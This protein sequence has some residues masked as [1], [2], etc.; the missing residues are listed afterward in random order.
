M[1]DDT[2]LRGGQWVGGDRRRTLYALAAITVLS[3]LARL[4]G[5]GARIFHWDEGRVGY[6]ILRY[7]ESGL[8]E[9]RPIVHGPF[10]YHVNDV[11]FA[12]IGA[13]DFSARLVVALVG[14]LLPLAA[15]LF[16][17]HLEDTELVAL[18]L[19]LAANP[20]LLYYSRFM[21][22]DVLLAAFMLFA[23]G[24]F[25]R[26]VDTGSTW[27]LYPG[28]LAFALGF[29]TKENAILYPL[30]WAGAVVL[31]LDHRLL[32][33]GRRPSRRVAR[34][35]RSNPNTE[36]G[37][38]ADSGSGPESGGEAP[39]AESLAGDG[40]TLLSRPLKRTRSRREVAAE[41]AWAA[42]GGL[43][44]WLG[45][46]VLSAALFLAVIVLFYAPRTAGEGVGFGATLSDPT[47]LPAL[48]ETTLVDTGTAVYDLW[49]VGGHQDHAYLPFLGGFLET[50]AYG[51]AT[52]SLLAVVGVLADRYSGDGPR[53]FVSLA[54]YWGFVSVLGYPI[55]TDIEAPWA[56]V[57]AIVPLAVPAAVGAALLFRW[58]RE[59]IR[60]GDVVGIA[61]AVV[62]VVLAAGTTA[63]TA[64]DAAYLGSTD[65]ENEEV[66]QWA[67]PGNDLEPVLEDV[68]EIAAN[69]RGTDVLFWGT[70]RPGSDEELLY[71]ANESSDRQPGAEGGWYDRLP[72]PWY[73]E[74]YDANVTSTP[75]SANPEI[76]LENPPPVVIAYDW[77]RSDLEPHLEGYT[78][79]EHDF[80][81][82]QDEIVVFV[83]E[84]RLDG[85]DTSDTSAARPGVEPAMN[86]RRANQPAGSTQRQAMVTAGH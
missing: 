83:D 2:G 17:E 46:L 4:V 40:G 54:F 13:S 86:D 80:R 3:L 73:L 6:W 38:E 39:S 18:G 59:A 52:L 84:S 31:L 25:V 29:T 30:C 64:A 55:V 63:A 49:V 34:S 50:M 79:S 36:S 67:Q 10:L 37:S 78:V 62:I 65:R 45:P 85:S 56:T 53:D 77:N 7:A 22:N 41:Y 72:L 47:L 57:H 32:L 76:A 15:W 69:N 28:T 51:A 70:V 11:V 8:W 24:F 16:H 19:F 12:A 42:F 71:V 9:Y 23:L 75:P 21:R 27:Y 43:R 48:V 44:R 60:D 20:V 68:G 74:R 58:G 81:L 35:D 82:W 1:D 61:L 5:L 14:G 33:A 66:L 26:A